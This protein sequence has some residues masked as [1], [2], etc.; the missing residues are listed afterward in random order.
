MAAASRMYKESYDTQALP[1]LQIA[2]QQ[3]AQKL[4]FDVPA[5]G[6][7]H[8]DGMDRV[9]SIAIRIAENHH[10]DAHALA[11]QVQYGRAD[12]LSEMKSLKASL[13]ILAHLGPDALTADDKNALALGHE[14]I[15]AMIR[16][17]LIMAEY[18]RPGH[19]I[20]PQ[21]LAPDNHSYW[22]ERTAMITQSSRHEPEGDITFS[23]QFGYYLADVQ[24]IMSMICHELGIQERL[25]QHH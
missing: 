1:P 19:R 22:M 10:D 15:N 8:Y 9:L 13:N 11:L 5:R 14:I 16:Q 21:L 2:T 3:R 7:H 24:K 25:P 4:L 6:W 12:I 20:D 23:M 18:N 17:C